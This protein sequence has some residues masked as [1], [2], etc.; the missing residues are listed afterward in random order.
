MSLR[1]HKLILAALVLSSPVLCWAQEQRPALIPLQ[2]AGS[3]GAGAS[4]TSST[5]SIGGLTDGPIIAGEVVH[6]NVFDA[7]DFSI[8]TRVSDNG[9]IPYPILGVVHIGGLTSATAADLLA[10]QLKERNLMLDPEVTVTVDSAA[11]G[12]TVLGEVRAP[13][14]Y[15][16]PGKHLLSDL[17]ATAGGLTANTGRIIEISNDRTPDK[18]TYISWDPTM[19]NTENF[20]RPVSPGDRVLVRAC[21]I[22][23]VG[24]NVM[25]PGAYSLCGSQRMTLSVIMA[26]AGG[27]APS[28]SLNHTYLVRSQPDGTKIVQQIDVKK[29]LTSRVADPI[30]QEDDIIYVSPSS[31]KTVL[32][33][34]IAFVIGISPT[35]LYSYHP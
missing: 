14:V 28:S 34:A 23:Y 11:T 35:L 2:Q 10:K 1:D 31:M 13:G 3:A 12:I 29:V 18:K 21:G 16:P 33:G 24:G 17:L 25:K 5:A 26:L 15:P 27:V 7:P 19:H 6:I 32:K 9:D 8:I 22:A 4:G 30:V 20:D